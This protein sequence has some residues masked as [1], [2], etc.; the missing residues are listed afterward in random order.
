MSW[1]LAT[2]MCLSYPPSTVV[3]FNYRQES[4]HLGK[5][6]TQIYPKV[7]VFTHVQNQI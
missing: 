2:L 3:S 6:I 5:G 4:I 7:A 1:T